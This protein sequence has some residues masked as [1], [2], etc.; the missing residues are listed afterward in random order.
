MALGVYRH[1][2]GRHL[3]QCGPVTTLVGIRVVSRKPCPG[4][5]TGGWGPPGCGAFPQHVS[6]PRTEHSVL[7]G[8]AG[9]S[10]MRAAWLSRRQPP[11][12]T[13][14]PAPPDK[15]LYLSYALAPARALRR[16]G[17]PAPG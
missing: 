15:G 1:G 2:Q 8:P 11:P 9:G 6:A 16:R 17:L 4:L 3:A 14:P 10:V 5:Q 13:S 12:A 7:H